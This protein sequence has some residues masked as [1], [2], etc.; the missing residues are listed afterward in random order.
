M[1]K[2]FFT[3][4]FD[5]THYPEINGDTGTLSVDINPAMPINVA[6]HSHN[7]DPRRLPVFSAEDFFKLYQWY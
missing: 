4:P 2:D 1:K 7:N 5:S 3:D 6:V